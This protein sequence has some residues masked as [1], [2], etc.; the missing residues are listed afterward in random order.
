M[1]D[2]EERCESSSRLI[3][4]LLPWLHFT[5]L[6][7]LSVK[8]IG[9]RSDVY[10]EEEICLRYVRVV[11]SNH[12]HLLIP[13]RCVSK[14]GQMLLDLGSYPVVMATLAAFHISFFIA[15]NYIC[16]SGCSALR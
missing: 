2:F 10:D 16:V 11:E 9:R 14:A 7:F 12:H 3:G 6:S 5:V 4:L 8:F 15:L 13:A 1:I